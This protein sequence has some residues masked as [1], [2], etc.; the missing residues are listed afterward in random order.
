MTIRTGKLHVQDVTCLR[1]EV[2]KRD[3]GIPIVQIRRS[4]RLDVEAG[5]TD[6]RCI[7]VVRVYRINC[8]IILAE[9]MRAEERESVFLCRIQ[10]LDFE[11][12]INFGGKIDR[13]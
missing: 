5:G 1:R 6:Q 3:Y 2:A 8:C 12:G 10:I 9:F 13:G 11:S 4:G 7:S